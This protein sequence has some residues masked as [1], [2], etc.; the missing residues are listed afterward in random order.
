MKFAAFV[1]LALSAAC[2][3]T[4]AGLAQQVASPP[5]EQ[6][7]PDAAVPL[8]ASPPVVAAPPEASKFAPAPAQTRSLKKLPALAAPAP[9]AASK[10]EPG[11]PD[12]VVGGL[13]G[14]ESAT[15]VEKQP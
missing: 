3:E 13:P 4:S 1:L 14:N 15:A 10:P 5:V 12:V 6:A 8:P 9:A 2:L 11:T 7:A